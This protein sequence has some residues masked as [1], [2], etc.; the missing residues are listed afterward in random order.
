MPKRKR[1][2]PISVERARQFVK[3][4][5]VMLRDWTPLRLDEALELFIWCWRHTA[6]LPDD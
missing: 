4:G 5:A 1:Q 2:H 3:V 6:R